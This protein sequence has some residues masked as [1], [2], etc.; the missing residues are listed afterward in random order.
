M[1]NIR[2]VIPLLYS[3]P[4]ITSTITARLSHNR[5]NRKAGPHPVLSFWSRFS[6]E[7][8]ILCGESI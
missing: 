1:D 6:K 3:R 4:S 7:W 2:D 5:N 8:L